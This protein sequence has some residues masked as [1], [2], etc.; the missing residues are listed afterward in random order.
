MISFTKKD[1]ASKVY[2]LFYVNTFKCV[3]PKH[4]MTTHVTLDI[5]SLV[6]KIMVWLFFRTHTHLQVCILR[7]QNEAKVRE[8]DNRL[9]HSLTSNSALTVSLLG[10]WA[11]RL[12]TLRR[13]IKWTPPLPKSSPGSSITVI[14][15]TRRLQSDWN[16]SRSLIWLVVAGEDSIW[17]VSLLGW[18]LDLNSL[19]RDLVG[20]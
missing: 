5:H 13:H 18:G 17:V 10:I 19:K 4:G 12:L 14:Q 11:I 6:F 16:K 8:R 2:D 15:N 1:I 7:N 3:F 20:F 9:T